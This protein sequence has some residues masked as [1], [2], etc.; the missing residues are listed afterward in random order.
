[1]IKKLFSV[2]LIACAIGTQAQQVQNAGFET[3]TNN[4]P[5]NWGSIGGAL[6]GFGQPNPGTETQTTTKHSG[7]YAVLLTNKAVAAFGGAVVPGFVQTGSAAVVGTSLSFKGEPYTYQPSSYSF[8]YEYVPQTGD[9]G[10]TQILL[11][12]WNTGTNT[13]DTLAFGGATIHAAANYT[14]GTVPIIWQTVANPDTI[15]LSFGSS[16]LNTPPANSM[17]YVDD[18]TMAVSGIQTFVDGSVSHVYPNPASN[19]IN[20]SVS[21]ENAKYVKVYD[22]TGRAVASF[23]LINRSV[24]ADVSSFENGM[25]IYVI[26]DA[27]G[28]KMGT[29][30]F[31]VAK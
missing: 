12:K 7:T 28:G 3:W 23:E 18:V 24:K 31:N 9:S 4:F 20:F 6:V 10:F 19:T 1:M 15:L 16:Q 26:T 21:D 11:T 17:L 13:R 2:A 5:N 8:Y 14:Q 30:K 29:A 25:Y 22:L 27:Q